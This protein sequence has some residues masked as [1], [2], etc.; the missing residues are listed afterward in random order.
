ML[1]EK[2]DFSIEKMKIFQKTRFSIFSRKIFISKK[3][4]FQKNI[5]M[6][7]QNFP[8]IPKIALRNACDECKHVKN[9]FYKFLNTDYQNS[10]T[11]CDMLC[12]TTLKSPGRLKSV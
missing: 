10:V 12:V 2:I 6:S 4:R 11:F 5:S 3:K 1:L 9:A 7:I 8:K